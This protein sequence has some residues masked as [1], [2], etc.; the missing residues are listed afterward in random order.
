[1]LLGAVY[2]MHDLDGRGPAIGAPLTEW[3]SHE[4]ICISLVPPALSGLVCPFGG[5][6]LRSVAIPT[7]PE[8]IHVWVVPG[9]PTRFGDLDEEWRAEYLASLGQ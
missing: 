3:H 7:T 9:A 2:E 6:P 8:M 1:M 5:C 4:N